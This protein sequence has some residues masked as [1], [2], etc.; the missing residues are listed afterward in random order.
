MA[1]DGNL[2]SLASD[3]SYTE[4]DNKCI[5]TDI[6]YVMWV[7]DKYAGMKRIVKEVTFSR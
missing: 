2:E 7:L 3:A 1:F 6:R 5:N 4:G